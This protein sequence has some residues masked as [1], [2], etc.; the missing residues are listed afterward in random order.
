MAKRIASLFRSTEG[1][2]APTVAL[3]LVG[4]IAVGGIAFDYAR[5]V[6]MHSELQNAADQAALAAATQLDGRPDAM[7]RATT[8]AN[9]LVSNLT[10]LSNDGEGGAVGVASVSFYSDLSKTPAT[11]DA[12]AR[13]AE[14]LVDGRQVFYALTPIVNL[15]SSGLIDAQAMAGMGSA[16]CK[17]PPVM[18]CNPAETTDP[19]FTV[20]NYVGKGL[21]LVAVGGNN[22][23]NGGNET[24]QGAGSAWAPGNFGYLD[25]SGG[26]NGVPGLREALGWTSV[27]GDCSPS[28]GVDTKPGANVSVTDSLN[29]RFDIGNSHPVCPNGGACPPSAN[30]VKDLIKTDATNGQACN[31]HNNGWR[32]SS[33]PYLPSSTTPLSSNF[34]DAM[35]HPRDI[36]HAVTSGTSGACTGPI[37]DG[38]WDIDAYFR[39]NYNGATSAQWKAA[40]STSA[41]YPVTA[42]GGTPPYGVTRYEVYRW[43]MANAG[44]SLNGQTV[45]G[46]RTVSGSGPNTLRSRGGAYCTTPGIT[47]GGTTPDRRRISV[48]VVNCNAENVRGNSTNVGVVKW[49]DVFLV[50]PSLNRARTGAGDVYVEVIEQ[51]AANSDGTA[52]QVVRRDVPYLVE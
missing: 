31:I 38:V 17:V 45:L 26:S 6:G 18:I 15:M 11:S 4:L 40:L 10:R 24:T 47:P 44:T 22:H 25:T 30:S 48:A 27:P 51:A 21:K 46:P 29:T 9:D 1:A 35:G 13:F 41:N 32:V 19:D 7:A 42:T 8:A 16:T 36:C 43:E 34:P 5:M 50:E 2:V 39:V 37:G 12:N 20:G 28:T 14:V 3:A 52:G 49:L 23:N 33:N